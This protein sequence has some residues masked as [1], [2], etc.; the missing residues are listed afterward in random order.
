MHSLAVCIRSPFAARRQITNPHKR[1]GSNSSPLPPAATAKSSP[2]QEQPKGS[3]SKQQKTLY[4]ENSTDFRR[5]LNITRSIK[6]K[7]FVH[8]VLSLSCAARLSATVAFVL[9][10]GFDQ[11]E[12]HPEKD[13]S[14]FVFQSARVFAECDMHKRVYS[15]VSS[16]PL[17]CSI[18]DMPRRPRAWLLYPAFQGGAT[19]CQLPGPCGTEKH[20]LVELFACEGLCGSPAREDIQDL[21]QAI[22]NV[23]R[24]WT[25]ANRPGHVSDELLHARHRGRCCF[26]HG[27]LASHDVVLQLECWTCSRILAPGSSSHSTCCHCKMLSPSGQPTT[28]L[29]CF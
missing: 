22:G 16:L 25:C 19:S 15:K 6:S 7:R 3:N 14:K 18:E 27:Y 20:S 2:S 9:T 1:A 24:G 28:P 11:P 26:H 12:I 13:E 10:V 5:P 21:S 17:T 8:F 29:Q 4:H 23:S